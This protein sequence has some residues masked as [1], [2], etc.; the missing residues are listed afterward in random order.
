MGADN[1]TAASAQGYQ[2]GRVLPNSP[3]HIAGLC[4]FFDI[5][6]GI[7]DIALDMD[8][9]DYFKEYVARNAGTPVRF[10]LYNLRVRA[11]RVVAVTPTDSWGGAG[12]L[13][14]AMEWTSASTAL[15]LTW[16][17]E[18]LH[19]NGPAARCGELEAGRDYI[20]GMQ[21]PEEQ[22]VTL[23]THAT[24]AEK[25]AGWR[26]HRRTTPDMDP[27]E[28]EALLLLVY[29]SAANEVREVLVP[30]G[31]SA[32]LGVDIA[33]GYLH[34][35]PAVTI[36]DPAEVAANLPFISRFVVEGTPRLCP[37]GSSHGTLADADGPADASAAPREG[38]V[39]EEAA[40]EPEVPAVE[41][42]PPVAM[43]SPLPIPSPFPAPPQP[44]AAAAPMP[45]APS[46]PSFLPQVPG[47]A[48]TAPSIG[49]LPFPSFSVPPPVRPPQPAVVPQPAE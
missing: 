23:F 46:F 4:P 19:P 7:D 36:N 29:D 10:T 33:D 30:M 44:S 24:F 18:A 15:E 16:H 35:V 34:H 39:V 31:T 6:T 47:A 8:S 13:G 5:I 25:M 42:K 11:Y 3:A 45:Q 2:V 1:S 32:S 17:I 26:S 49:A 14:C 27:S 40:A 37:A 43:P 41:E 28:R 21:A 12:L 22:T 48:P 38:H 20:V 9:I